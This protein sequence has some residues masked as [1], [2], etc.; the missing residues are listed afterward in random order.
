MRITNKNTT[1]IV[2]K[3]IWR[4]IQYMQETPD[5]SLWGESIYQFNISLGGG[6][7]MRGFASFIRKANED[8]RW[9]LVKDPNDLIKELL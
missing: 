8:L 6:S 7:Y 9:S 3:E 5:S 4:N 2:P 1:G